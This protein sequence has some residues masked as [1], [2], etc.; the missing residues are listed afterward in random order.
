MDKIIMK[1][2]SIQ[3]A[4][5]LGIDNWEIWECEPSIFDWEFTELETCYFFE[6]DVIVTAGDEVAHIKEGMLVSFPKDMKCTWNVS[7]KIRKA[8]TY[9]YIIE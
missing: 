4:K 6:G 8:Y 5:K 3:D 1:E 2:M 9:N 7:K